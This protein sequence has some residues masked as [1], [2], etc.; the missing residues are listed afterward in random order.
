M[1]NPKKSIGTILFTIVLKRTKSFSNKFN[2][3]PQILYTAN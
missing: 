3:V 2:K 1:C